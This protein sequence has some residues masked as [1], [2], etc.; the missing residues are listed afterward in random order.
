MSTSTERLCE[1]GCGA[2]TRKSRNGTPN[3]YLQGHNRRG[4]SNPNGYINQGH[5]YIRVD[6]VTRALHRVVAEQALG[7]PLRPE[8]IVHHIDGDPLNNESSNLAVVSRQE[9]FL[10]HMIK[11][12]AKP[13]SEDE[14]ARAA[15]LYRSG[16]SIDSVAQMVGRSYYAT[17]RLLNRMQVLRTGAATRALK[18]SAQSELAGVESL[19]A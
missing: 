8:E 2:T 10:L 3:R 14:I 13:W 1:C 19:A 4:T 5:R 15:D 17:R 7:R 16:M 12:T 6:G 11:E 18:A 9:H